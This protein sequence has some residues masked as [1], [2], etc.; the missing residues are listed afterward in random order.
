[1][2]HLFVLSL[3]A[4]VLPVLLLTTVSKSQSQTSTAVADNPFKNDVSHISKKGGP[5]T[6][7]II[8]AVA[9]PKRFRL[10]RSTT[11]TELLALVGGTVKGA[12]GR[13]KV[14]RDS[15]EMSCCGGSEISETSATVDASNHRVKVDDYDLRAVLR[16]EKGSDVVLNPNEEITITV[17]FAN[18][19]LVLG[20]VAEPKLLT[21]DKPITLAQALILTGGAKATAK[22]EEV[23]IKR[24][25]SEGT[26]PET[27]VVNL[28]RR[29]GQD[30]EMLLKSND[31]IFVP[32]SKG[33]KNG[34]GRKSVLTSSDDLSVEVMQ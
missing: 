5:K 26:N 2:K 24:Q 4:V 29:N 12:S 28:R 6:V 31:I 32:R 22:T 25:S 17:P 20:C 13:L 30:A 10:E 23:Q 15:L 11:I 14:N 1:M 16:R 8:G 7:R 3:I 33:M 19:I 34:C 18:P 9:T 21:P 27:I